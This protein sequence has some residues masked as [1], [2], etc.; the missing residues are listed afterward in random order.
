MPL[1]YT[2]HTHIHSLD[3]AFERKH[4]M[5][6]LLSLAWSNRMLTSVTSVSVHG[7]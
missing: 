7:V 4:V 1:T 6:I 5:S 2:P 3:S